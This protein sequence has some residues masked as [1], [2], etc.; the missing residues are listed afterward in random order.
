MSAV[1]VAAKPRLSYQEFVAKQQ[2]GPLV[3]D[4]IR[5]YIADMDRLGKPV[6]KSGGYCLNRLAREPIGYKVAAKLTKQDVVDH[7][8]MRKDAGVVPATAMKDLTHLQVIFKFARSAWDVPANKDAIEDAKPLLQKLGLIGKSEPRSRR[9]TDEEHARLCAFFVI[10]N[11]SRRTKVPMEV[12]ADFQRKSAR[13]I[14]ETCRI[15][16]VDWSDEHRVVLVRRMKDPRSRDKNKLVALPEGANDII[17]ARWIA[18]PGELK[19]KVFDLPVDHPDQPRIF[20]YGAQTCSA[21]YTEAKKRL[22]IDGLH[23]HDSR[24]DCGT[25][26]V[27]EDGYSVEQALLVTG[28][29][30]DAIFRRVYLKMDPAKFKD[31]PIAQQLA[32]GGPHLGEVVATLRPDLR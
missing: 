6:I 2:Q 12:V 26:L 25:R 31:G 22:G 4:V 20:P 16:F 11:A 19:A 9:P 14:S 7:V 30:G 13:R 15:T 23:L 18:L 27:E 10:Q 17:R 21:R 32:R 28:H 1:E 3:G 5:R 29:E 24:R 8:L